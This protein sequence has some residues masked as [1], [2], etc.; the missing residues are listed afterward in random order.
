MTRGKRRYCMM[1]Y[2]KFFLI[3]ISRHDWPGLASSWSV[4]RELWASVYCISFLLYLTFVRR[5]K[6][7]WYKLII[8]RHDI[9]GDPISFLS[10]HK[11]HFVH[12]VGVIPEMID[13]W[14]GLWCIWRIFIQTFIQI[15]RYLEFEVTSGGPTVTP[16]VKLWSFLSR[17]WC[18]S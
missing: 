15:Y 17:S 1:W 8:C 14:S 18:R 13:S 16:K 10:M 12:W 7:V 5:F 2:V 9:F 11:I 6:S 4:P 3:T